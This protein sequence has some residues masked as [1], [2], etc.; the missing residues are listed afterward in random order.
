M[1]DSVEYN[2]PTANNFPNDYDQ[3]DVDSRTALRTKSIRSKMYGK[4][5]REAIA[6]GVEISSVVSGQAKKTADDSIALSKDTQAQ[7]KAVQQGATSDTEVKTARYSKADDKTY[8]VL[9]DRLD[10]MDT[11]PQQ[12]VDDLQI[13]DVNLLLDTDRWISNQ[14][15]YLNFEIQPAISELAGKNVTISFRVDF[16]KVTALNDNKRVVMGFNCNNGTKTT[17]FD[18]PFFPNV[19][20]SYHGVIT[21]S[22]TIP[23]DTTS[24]S[25]ALFNQGVVASDLKIGHAKLQYGS[26][27]TG[28][29]PNPADN[30]HHQAFRKGT[31]FFA[32][33]GNQNLAPE[34]SLPAI[35]KTANHA[36]VE[37]DIH[38]TSDGVWV[39]MHDGT[40]NRMT[41]STGA[42]SSFTFS[43]IRKLRITKG[44]FAS[45]Y[46]DDEL[47]IP[48][49]E[50]VLTICKDRQLVPV[51]EIKNDSSDN[52]TDDSWDSLANIIT[53]F[54]L[55]DEMMFISFS[56]ECL[57]AIKRRLP[58]VEASYLVNDITNDYITQAQQLGV[59]SG[60]DVNYTGSGVT[61]NNVSLCHQHGLKV[62]VWTTADDS[63]RQ[64]LVGMG[65]D[66]ITTNS[67]SG[68]LRE[69]SLSL[70]NGWK[71]YPGIISYVEE[72]AKG[73]VQIYFLV[74]GGTTTHDLTL[75]NLPDWATPAGVE[76]LPCTVR[77]SD[78]VALGTFDITAESQTD[79]HVRIG[80]GWDQKK[81]SGQNGWIAG[82]A[83]YHI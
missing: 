44:S 7:F 55:Q 62:G 2:D 66:F 23:S 12:A 72:I 13:Q 69:Q 31:R 39:V 67:L 43:D 65:V 15:P 8:D 58:L 9:T 54:G 59:N 29:S 41:N 63:Q 28:W 27:S 30:H 45:A 64:K 70:Q 1:A 73:T 76:Y 22:F 10:A 36:G 16:D 18:K 48:T 80:I 5:V 75:A 51:V 14:G 46:R 56:Y 20:D 40:V 25:V 17:Y 50:E 32:H 42:I 35:R 74:Y 60:L 77:T 49:L 82:S 26:K 24:I 33:R 61:A 47:L 78:G 38:Q 3:K 4:D 37:I 34:N 79:T 71:N 53:K 21:S 81:E 83:T 11:K 68:E 52:Y 19:G 6:E 57:Q